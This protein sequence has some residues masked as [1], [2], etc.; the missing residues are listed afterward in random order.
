MAFDLDSALAERR[1]RHQYRQRLTLSGGSGREA[2]LAGRRLIN[3]ASNDY[4]G[5]AGHPHVVAAM[6]DAAARYGV[7][8]GASHLVTGHTDLH[9]ALEEELAAFTGRP[10]ALLFSTG[11]MANQG[12]LT[13]CSTA[14]S[15]VAPAFA[16]TCTTSPITWPASWRAVRHGASWW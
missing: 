3:F 11:Y 5:L 14:G 12:I 10:R 13:P 16:V 1:A 15:P 9:E 4:L 6:Q 2:R 7:G 8:S